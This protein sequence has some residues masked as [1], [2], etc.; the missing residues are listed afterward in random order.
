MVRKHGPALTLSDLPQVPS[1]H[2]VLIFLVQS[3]DNVSLE[4][5]YGNAQ[6][7]LYG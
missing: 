5:G 4:G 3:R 6:Y 7:I 1:S 2:P